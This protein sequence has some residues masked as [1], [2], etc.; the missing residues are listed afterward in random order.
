MNKR[1]SLFTAFIGHFVTN[2][3]RIREVIV[4]LIVLICAGGFGVSR[5]EG[6]RLG[7]GFYFAFITA[8]SVG[9]GDITPQT[10][11]GKILS[12][13]IGLVGML[14][15]GITVAVATRALGDTAKNMEV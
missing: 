1:L 8:L 2:A 6:L 5:L 12:V 9:Y 4:T 13:A 7:D 14:F 11:L 3:L 10:T 15:V